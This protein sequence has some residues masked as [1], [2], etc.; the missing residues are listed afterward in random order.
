M[1]LKSIR[2]HMAFGTR[3]GGFTLVELLIA[4]V[5]TGIIGL[6]T[7]ANYAA[8]KQ[9]GNKVRQIAQMQQ[10]LRGAMFIMDLD[11]RITGY[12][13]QGNG[14]FGVI[15]VQRW[16][17]TDEN[18]LP[19]VDAAGSP[20]ITVAYDWDPSNPAT[21]GNGLVDEPTPAYRL[22]DDNSDGI[23]DLVRDNGIPNRSLVAEGI[24]AIGFAYAYDS[25][26][27]GDIDRNAAGNMIWAV[28]SDNDNRLDTNLDA[29]ND[30]VIDLNDDT[31]GD[32]RITTADGAPLAL[33]VDVDRIRM[34]RV[35]LLA[36]AAN[37]S[38]NFSNQGQFILVGDQVVPNQPG[39]FNDNIPRRLLIRTIE[40]RN[41]GI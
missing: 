28:D 17:I 15:N 12:D 37:A 24:D 35:W 26:G 34:V 19:A 20:S 29:N 33:P 22:F 32:L 23:F 38:R 36:R 4:I 21:T 14:G 3:D 2:Q 30:G 11:F 9:V 16:S 25:N 7:V 1:K 8:Q 41:T 10:Q 13:P 27:D 40:C 6:S 31:D 18:T 5:V 39:G